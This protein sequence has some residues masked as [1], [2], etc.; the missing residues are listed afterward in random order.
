MILSVKGNLAAAAVADRFG[1]GF[2]ASL[3]KRSRA[4]V[5]VLDAAVVLDDLRF[6]LGNHLE[7]LKGDR[8]SQ[9]SVWIN[10]QSRICFRWKEHGPTEV[11]IVDY[12]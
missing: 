12:H 9:P 10:S 8:V 5:S 7:A 11:E 6:P 3:I 1:K 2:P 4:M